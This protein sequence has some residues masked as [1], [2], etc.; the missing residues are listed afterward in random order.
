MYEEEGV[1]EICAAVSVYEMRTCEEVST[2]RILY[3]SV[4]AYRHQENFRPI[5]GSRVI[6][7]SNVHYSLHARLS[8]LGI[9]L[10]T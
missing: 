7:P 1:F 6:S 4:G 9:A 3:S 10:P 5:P 2:N 8:T